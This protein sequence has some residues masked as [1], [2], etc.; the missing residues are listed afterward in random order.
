M[1]WLSIEAIRDHLYSTKS[2][3]WA[4]SVVL[5]EI[6]TLGHIQM[7]CLNKLIYKKVNMFILYLG[8]FPYPTV[9][10]HE[11][12]SFLASGQR[13]QRPENCSQK[14]YDLML[15]CWSEKPEDRPD[16]IE[17]V[18]HLEQ[19]NQKIYVDFSELSSDYVFPPTKEQLQNNVGI[20]K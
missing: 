18:S 16:F 14:L 19:S 11:L 3:V 7:Q 1:R 13:L 5:W 15:E 6:G 12:L 10:N 20:Q 4:F 8:G 9:G 2:D 17:I